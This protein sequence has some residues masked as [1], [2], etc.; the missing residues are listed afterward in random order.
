MGE[1]ANAGACTQVPKLSMIFTTT[2]PRP[3]P[4]HRAG[5]PYVHF[6]PYTRAE[7]VHMVTLET[8]PLP[9]NLRHGLNAEDLP[10]IYKQF[11]ITVYDALIAPTTLSISLYKQVLGRLWPRF[12]WPAV[13][14]EQPTGRAKVWD[15][16]RLLIRNRTL[17]HG[18]GESALLD[19]LEGGGKG[20]GFEDLMREQEQQQQSGDKSVGTPRADQR[21]TTATAGTQAD[22]NTPLLAPLPTLLLLAT[23]LCSHTPSKHDI[24]LFSRLSNSATKHRKIRYI[25]RGN[26]GTTP[27]K[28]NEDGRRKDKT[29]SLAPK[30][31][32]LERILA[33]G[34]AVSV[35]D[36]NGA[37]T[38]KHRGKREKDSAQG[39]SD[40]VAR[41]MGELERMRLVR[42]EDGAVSSGTT[43][44]EGDGVA[45]STSVGS[46][47]GGRWRI[48][49]GREV[50]EELAKRCGLGVLEWELDL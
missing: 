17:F 9:D 22:Q 3:L 34:R 48:N 18:A 15:F 43:G 8:H 24:L 28:A 40:R 38:S 14:G 50:V 44:G 16:S 23:H 19:S 27:K 32:G 35:D 6:P 5:V 33:V 37:G 2:S 42:R 30:A 31:C 36:I 26:P 10:K 46:L 12:V 39:W 1:E 7:A 47:G 13:C 49:V 45:S 29:K 25:K 20:W 41:A 21:I 4:L 11:A